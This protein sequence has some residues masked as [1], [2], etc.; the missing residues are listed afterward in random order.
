MVTQ[1]TSL[2]HRSVRENILL[3]YYLNRALVRTPEAEARAVELAEEMGLGHALR[4]PIS[5]VRASARSV[6]PNRMRVSA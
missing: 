3:P 4:R 5:P 2:L 6:S 1:D